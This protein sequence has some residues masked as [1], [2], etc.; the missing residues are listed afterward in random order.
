MVTKKLRFW[1]KKSKSYDD[2][3]HKLMVNQQKRFDDER[4]RMHKAMD[5]LQKLTDVVDELNR[6][7]D[8]GEITQEEHQK[9]VCEATGIKR[10][11]K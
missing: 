8:T 11:G 1:D 4:Q 6:K 3:L 9:L 5:N 2:E 7:R 10:T